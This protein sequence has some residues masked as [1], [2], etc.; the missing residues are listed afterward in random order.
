MLTIECLLCLNQSLKHNICNLDFNKRF[1]TSRESNTINDSLRYSCVHWASHLVHVLEGSPA[2]S[3]VS[4]V[5][6]LLSEFVGEHLLHWFEC[7]SALGELESGVKCLDKASEA[8]SVSTKFFGN[9]DIDQSSLRPFRR[10]TVD[11]RA[12]HDSSRTHVGSSNWVLSRS[13]GTPLKPIT[14]HWYG[15]Q[16]SP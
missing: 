7:L 10:S 2:Q 8:T 1:V 6:G 3:S 9:M 12:Y 13:T 11:L 15:S 14:L 16:R 4:E 5:Q